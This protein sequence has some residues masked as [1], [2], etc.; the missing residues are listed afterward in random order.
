MRDPSNLDL[1]NLLL[2][3]RANLQKLAHEET[4]FALF[5]LRKTYFESGDKAGKMLANRLKQIEN[6]QIIPAIRDEHGMLQ[7]DAA[8]INE[9]FKNYYS[10]LYSTE[11]NCN[12][13]A[14][15]SFFGGFN[16]PTVS[17]ADRANM[18]AP[19]TQSEIKIAIMKMSSGKTPGD[20]G[21]GIEFYKC[22]ID[23]LSPYLLLLFNEIL[24]SECM[25]PSMSRAIISLLPKPGKDP[26]L[27]GNHRPLSLL[28]C[29]YKIL[30]KILAL[31][32]EKVVP[33]VVH[34]DQVGFIPG[35]QSSNNMRRVFQIILKASSSNLPVITA[36][37]DAEKAFDQIEWEYLLYTLKNL[38][39]DPSLLAG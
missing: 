22:F 21:L 37:L 34:L 14:L 18:E 15:N 38:V 39:L 31:R 24:E 23:Q 20:D 33:S 19:V 1:R 30:A 29:D 26:A 32:L 9:S 6:R 35:H 8:T 28:N 2:T 4:V 13:E 7:C 12:K 11:N 10:N 5:R 25:P 36:S 3:A 27:M 17:S 16:L